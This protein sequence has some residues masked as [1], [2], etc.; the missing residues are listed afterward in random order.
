VG[1][2]CLI[3]GSEP[4]IV[5]KG[6]VERLIEIEK[7]YHE[8]LKPINEAYYAE[9]KALAEKYEAIRKPIT[10]EFFAKRRELRAK[11]STDSS[12]PKE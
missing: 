11:V 12:E 9:K 8:K 3:I 6:S 2:S 5:G 1:A 7:W 4:K 10:D